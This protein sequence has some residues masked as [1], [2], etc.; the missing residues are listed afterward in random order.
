MTLREELYTESG[1][2]KWHYFQ[3]RVKTIKNNLK[4]NN[5]VSMFFYWRPLFSQLSKTIAINTSTFFLAP[6]DQ[7]LLI[8][9]PILLFFQIKLKNI[10]KWHY[11]MVY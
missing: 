7:L 1:S 2:M 4:T 10:K 3:H 5:G 8:L 9:T 11:L 6:S